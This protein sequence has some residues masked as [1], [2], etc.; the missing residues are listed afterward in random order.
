MKRGRTIVY[1][2]QNL[3]IHLIFTETKRYITCAMIFTLQVLVRIF[4]V[5]KNIRFIRAVCKY[6]LQQINQYSGSPGSDGVKLPT[7]TS[8]RGG[9]QSNHQG[10][11]EAGGPVV[12]RAPPLEGGK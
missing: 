11:Q 10:E 12:P 6:Y 9:A 5:F 2:S 1:L 4:Y 3:D 8:G 7:G